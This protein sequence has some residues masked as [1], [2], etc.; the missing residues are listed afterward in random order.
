MNVLQIVP[1][2]NAGGVE[3]TT[4]EI[5]EALYQAGHVP[6]VATRGGRLEKDLGAFK[7]QL[8]IYTKADKNPLHLPHHVSRLKN[9]IRRHAIDIVHARSRAPAWPALI[10]AQQTGVPFITTYHGIYNAKTPLKRFYNSVMARGD[11]IIAN[12]DFTRSHIITTHGTEPQKIT[13]I[14]R[15]VD[16]K[17]FDPQT[18][19]PMDIKSLRA[20][21][22]IDDSQTVVLLPGRI[23]RWKG[24]HIAV[25]ALAHLPDTCILVCLGDAQGRQDY[26]DSLWQ[27][28]RALGVDTR[29]RL[30][31]HSENM[32]T[33]LAAA[34]IVV[35]AS[36]EPEAFGRIAVE[37]QA[38]G[39]PIIA[40]AIG[41][42]LET[43]APHI[44]GQLVSPE[45]PEDL[46]HGIRH[47]LS[48]LGHYNAQDM[49]AR[50]REKFSKTAL[51]S[52]T[53]Q[54]YTDILL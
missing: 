18:L 26:V 38:M 1:E 15:A 19:K 22:H 3:R 35:S 30:P 13:T 29:L 42:S 50:V 5:A 47:V 8:H 36:I 4:V 51:Q 9:I 44:S 23:T 20:S 17:R 46:A 32:P 33:A 25:K 14:Y 27:N 31:G 12:S 37:A 10:A 41:G 45:D 7:T 39:K 40:T 48:S 28:A 54:I 53:L 21:W 16:L 24:Q 6:H 2:L 49:R 52:Q 11:H 43:I 34:D